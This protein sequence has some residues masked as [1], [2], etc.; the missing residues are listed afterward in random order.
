MGGNPSS[1]QQTVGLSVSVGL[2]ETSVFFLLF[3][4]SL[5]PSHQIPENQPESQVLWELMCTVS[6]RP[7]AS[8]GS[9]EGWA[10][11]W[12]GRDPGGQALSWPLRG[13]IFA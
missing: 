1:Q 12:G 7:L 10:G 9:W 3:P 13:L 2:K 4:T 11:C 6:H 5:C 8:E